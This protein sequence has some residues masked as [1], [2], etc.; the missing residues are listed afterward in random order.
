[1]IFV[2][3]SHFVTVFAAGARFLVCPKMTGY[4]ST[5]CVLAQAVLLSIYLRTTM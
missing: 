4:T 5:T 1:V 3:T 2:S